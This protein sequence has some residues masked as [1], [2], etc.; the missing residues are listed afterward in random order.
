MKELR[1]IRKHNRTV[2]FIDDNFVANPQHIMK[3]CDAI[4]RER[5]NMFFMSTARADMVVR[6]PG[7]FKKM[8]EAG[9]IMVFLGLESF[10]DK[11]LNTLNKQFQFKQIKSAIKI[12]HNFGFFIQGNIILGAD[13]SDTETDLQS[14]I[15][16]AKSLDIDIPTFT[17]LTPY[18]GT[19]LMDRVIKENKLISQNWRDFNWVTP[20]MKYPH[21]TSDQLREYHLKAYAEVPVFS[22]ALRRINRVLR[23]HRLQFY[24]LRGLN[25]ETLKGIINVF[26]HQ[27][28]RQVREL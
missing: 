13:F 3:L 9:F 14:T 28:Y 23:F 12:L 15:D 26:K 1:E 2:Y 21:L 27:T 8:A 11:T 7:V 16:I 5:L 4:I 19:E 18:P 25:L 24:I 10:S 6:H 17:L 20:T 22:H